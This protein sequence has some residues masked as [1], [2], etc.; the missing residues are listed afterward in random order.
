MTNLIVFAIIGMSEIGPNVCKVDYMRYVDVESVTLPCDFI[1]LNTVS[2][3]KL[4]GIK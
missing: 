2:A 3:G 1:K 4:D